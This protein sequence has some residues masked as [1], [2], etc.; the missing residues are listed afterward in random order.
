MS[1]THTGERIFANDAE[2]GEAVR[3]VL[4][5]T[6]EQVV[7]GTGNAERNMSTVRRALSPMS[8][9]ILRSDARKLSAC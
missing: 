8:G 5:I 2:E 1:I 7:D 3:S 9:W 4:F 6:Q